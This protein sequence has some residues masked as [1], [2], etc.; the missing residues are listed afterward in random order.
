MIPAPAKKLSAPAGDAHAL[1]VHRLPV[2]RESKKAVT[3]SRGEMSE[4][5]SAGIANTGTMTSREANSI[6]VGIEMT[7]AMLP[8][9]VRR[10]D[11]HRLAHQER[12][13]MIKQ[14]AIGRAITS[15]AVVVEVRLLTLDASITGQ[16]KP[17]SRT[18]RLRSRLP[19][20]HL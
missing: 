7:D 20:Q 5:L 4:N 10:G 1:E 14:R 15:A 13:E 11:D 12:R 2:E 3:L 17:T 8:K 9:V 16:K 18:K 19:N 6:G